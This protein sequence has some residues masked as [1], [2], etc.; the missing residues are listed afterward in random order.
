MATFSTKQVKLR[1]GLLPWYLFNPENGIL[2]TSPTYPLSIQDRK[3][4]IYAELGV[5]G[6][7]Y[8]PLVPSRN[9][10]RKISFTLPI[11][12]RKGA[13]GNSN[14]MQAFEMLRNSDN[15]SLLPIFTGS[16][17]KKVQFES[18]PQV[19]YSWG[20]HST[21]LMYSVRKMDFTHDG[22]FTTKMGASAYTMV[23][24][25]L[26]LDENSMLYKM[27]N[28]LRVVQARAGL[29]QNLQVATSSGRP[30]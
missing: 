7:N 22:R 29:V 18:T 8:T 3:E 25:E 27:Q 23:E 30:Y 14:M 6:L 2:I 28:L 17:V 26:E 24:C 1:G 11:I 12:N 9:G 4:V 21:P 20:T 13:L 15:P 16:I 19:V 5:P 10:N